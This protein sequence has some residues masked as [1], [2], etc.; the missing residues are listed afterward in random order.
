VQHAPGNIGQPEIA[1]AGTDRKQCA[2]PSA[3]RA[4]IYLPMAGNSRSD[5]DGGKPYIRTITNS[6]GKLIAECI[7]LFCAT[8]FEPL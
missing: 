4:R 6:F 8:V 3:L 1:P 2:A 7:F 5:P